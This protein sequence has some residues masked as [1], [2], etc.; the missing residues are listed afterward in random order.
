MFML[1]GAPKAPKDNAV[2]FLDSYNVY[3]RKVLG[4]LPLFGNINQK[5]PTFW[6]C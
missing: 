6:L 4:W 3:M 2:T 5:S 1:K